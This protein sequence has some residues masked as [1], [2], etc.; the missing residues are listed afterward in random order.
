[1][2]PRDL[3]P[4]QFEEDGHR[5]A[6]AFER[7]PDGWICRLRRESDGTVQVLAFPD[8][9]GFDPDDVRDSLIA[10]CRAAVATLGWAGTTR[11]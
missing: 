4:H 1:M 2:K 8:G 5:F 3:E 7:S 11:H 10:G 6:V 9:P